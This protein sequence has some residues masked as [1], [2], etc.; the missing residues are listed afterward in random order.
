MSFDDGCAWSTS[1][2]QV[3]VQPADRV[4]RPQGLSATHASFWV[5]NTGDW[6]DVEYTLRKMMQCESSECYAF[7]SLGYIQFRSSAVGHVAMPSDYL[8]SGMKFRFPDTDVAVEI[9]Q[10]HPEGVLEVVCVLEY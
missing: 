7:Q 2:K 5:V 8:K 10:A 4:L 6:V 1:Q 3:G 9:V